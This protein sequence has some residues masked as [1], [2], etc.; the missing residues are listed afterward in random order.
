MAVTSA[1]TE[2]E[3]EEWKFHGPRHGADFDEKQGVGN[4]KNPQVKIKYLLR[5]DGPRALLDAVE[6]LAQAD[7]HS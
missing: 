2:G 7:G 3:R 4:K 1:Y 5:I 6:A